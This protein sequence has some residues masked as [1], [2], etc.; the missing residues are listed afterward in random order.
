MKRF[1]RTEEVTKNGR[2]TEIQHCLYD[3]YYNLVL[4][5]FSEPEKV[6]EIIE[7]YEARVSEETP[8]LEFQE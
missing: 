4:A 8:E 2:K 7:K 5:R 3:N 1:K 6:D